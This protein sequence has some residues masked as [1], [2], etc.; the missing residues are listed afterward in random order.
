MTDMSVQDYSEKSIVVRG[1]ETKKYKEELKTLGGKWN[2]GLQ[3]GGG[4]IFS[5]K[6]EDKVVAFVSTG[7]LDSKGSSKK[8]TP[9]EKAPSE[10]K[11][12]VITVPD[13]DEEEAPKA[14][15]KTPSEKTPSY[16]Q[17]FPLLFK[18]IQAAFAHV[19]PDQKFLLL[20]EITAC[21]CSA[22]SPPEVPKKEAPKK[23]SP[24]PK[25]ES[26]A[27]KKESPAPKKTLIKKVVEVKEDSDDDSD[28]PTP[29]P[30]PKKS[31]KAH[32]QENDSDDDSDTEPPKRLLTEK[33]KSD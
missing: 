23:E 13:Q 20:A 32:P 5:K 4:W 10:K 19:E 3:G 16:Q 11:V 7:K 29:K 31:E 15:K 1:E 22:G 28:E 14:S 12:T 9:S 27:P 8:E 6:L 2:A 33:R 21:A 18:Q 25:K 24:A 26:P 17:K 30:V